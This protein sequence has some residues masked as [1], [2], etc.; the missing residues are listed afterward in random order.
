MQFQ[1]LYSDITDT[2]IGCCFEVMNTLGTGFLESVYKNALVLS[3]KEKGLQLEIEKRFNVTYKNQKI[4]LFIADLVIEKKVI[5]ELKCCEALV[6]E[7]QA[8]LII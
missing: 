6:S 7:H 4:G 5:I 8:Q 2:I 1:K 3:L